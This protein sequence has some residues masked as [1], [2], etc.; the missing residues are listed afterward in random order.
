ML[1]ENVIRCEIENYIAT[2]IIDSPPANSLT[3]AAIKGLEQCVGDLETNP[4]VRAA[5]LTGTGKFFVAGADIKEFTG[6]SGDELIMRVRRGQALLNRLER[7]SFPVI[8]G[9][10][11]FALGGGLEVALACDIRIAS[12]KAKMGL[13]E[14]TL[15]IIPAYGGMSRLPA[16][17]G[18][19]NAKKLIFTAEILGAEAAMALGLL[20]E[21][22]PADL[23]AERCAAIAGQ[24]AAVAPLS[25]RMVKQGV[26]RRRDCDFASSL[27]NEVLYSAECFFTADRAEGIGAFIEK[28]KPVFTGR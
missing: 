20:Q 1:Y 15:G 21:V 9:I 14:A 11:G 24:I 22:V 25:V 12:D 7:L 8:A 6:W 26:R 17:I 4:G 2:I 23:L 10:N 18:E 19:G 5:V 16:I 3:E 13:P 28:R 27:E